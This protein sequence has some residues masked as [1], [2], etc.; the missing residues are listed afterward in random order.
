MTTKHS[1]LAQAIAE[2][3]RSADPHKREA[4]WHAVDAHHEELVRARKAHAAERRADLHDRFG[5]LVAF[6]E[7][8]K[9][10]VKRIGG[11]S[12]PPPPSVHPHDLN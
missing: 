7:R 2:G 12:S 10:A 5:R 8:V 9:E 4:F 11:G 3:C 1:T 6:A